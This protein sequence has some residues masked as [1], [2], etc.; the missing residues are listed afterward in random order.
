MG[1]GVGGNPT[2][3]AASLWGNSAMLWWASLA[4]LPIVIHL[5]SRT[6]FQR[7]DWAAMKFLEAAWKRHA[8]RLAIEQWVLLAVRCAMI[9]LVVLALA[10]PQWSVTSTD[11][12]RLRPSVH[13]V[14]ILD[15]TACMDGTFLGESRFDVAKQNAIEILDGYVEGDRFSLVMLADP[16]VVLIDEPTFDVDSARDALLNAERRDT[17]GNLAATLE[18]VQRIVA[19]AR[20]QDD[21]QQTRLCFFSSLGQSTW[22]AVETAECQRRIRELAKVA[23]LHVVEIPAV[24]EPNDVAIASVQLLDERSLVG[25]PLSLDVRLQRLAGNATSRKLSVL[26]DGQPGPILTASIL[27]VES[28]KRVDLEISQPG[29]H[30]VEFQIDDDSMPVN[31]RF[32]LHVVLRDRLRVLMLEGESQVGERLAVAL[33]P[34][35][36]QKTMIVTRTGLRELKNQKLSDFDVVFLLD[37]SVLDAVEQRILTKYVDD[38]GG[39]VWTAGPLVSAVQLSDSWRHVIAGD[40]VH[41][42]SVSERGDQGFDPIDYEHPILAAFSGQPR[43]GLLSTHIYSHLHIRVGADGDRVLNFSNGEPAIAAG[44]SGAGRW[45]FVSIPWGETSEREEANRWSEFTV[46]PA[47]LPLVH[48]TTH[49][50]MR[51]PHAQRTVTVGE[52][53]R[54]KAAGYSLAELVD[55]HDHQH[56]LLSSDSESFL[57]D[58][59]VFAGK[60]QFSVGE[61]ML[62]AEANVDIEQTRLDR[63]DTT[64]LPP[65][66]STDGTGQAIGT[67]ADSTVSIPLFRYVILAALLLFGAECWLSHRRRSNE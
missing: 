1:D 6:R 22:R 8:R 53:L 58:E 9:L 54:F 66:L 33:D 36:E 18:A 64:L 65:V 57:F 34:A 46:S 40:T 16:P 50:V 59:T 47:F 62:K 30:T 21:K 56:A 63:F 31:N 15:A 52:P 41:F 10:D 26:V 37:V 5:L 32:A 29:E 60:Y 14:L 35:G 11:V 67:P 43:S 51:R 49:W 55:P 48:E 39:I 4:C 13:W 61:N 3:F 2:V 38:G 45:V 42:D 19:K 27:G 20:E 28:R 12:P 7:T 25:E 44:Y 17:G 23:T 24:A